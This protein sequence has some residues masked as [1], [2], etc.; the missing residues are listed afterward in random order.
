MIINGACHCNNI[1]YQ[2]ELDSSIDKIDARQ[3]SCSFCTKQGVIYTSHP[4]G[5][6]SIKIKS[7]KDI[8]K[9]QFSS[10][11]I[12]FMFCNICGVMPFAVT[13]IENQ[14]YA[15]INIKTVNVELQ[16][17]HIQQNNFGAESIS[18]GMNR[19][20]LKWVSQISGL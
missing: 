4:S 10:K 2:Y 12:D 1:Q 13:L 7:L 6:L 9:Y 3:C 19:R 14:K 20:K 5:K 8:K 17:L 18:D 11:V 16:N 15:V